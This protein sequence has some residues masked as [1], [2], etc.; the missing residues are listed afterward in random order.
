MPS[1]KSL[2]LG[3]GAAAVFASAA[4]AN[5]VNAT[6]L[7]TGYGKFQPVSYNASTQWDQAGSGPFFSIRAFDHHWQDNDTGGQFIAW[8]IQL[9]QGLTV[10]NVYSFDCVAAENAPTAPPAPGPMGG[11]KA[12][13][14][15]DLFARWADVSTG[16]I[17]PEGTLAATN[18][19]A[20]GFSIVLWEVTHENFTAI[21]EAG[22][23]SQMSLSTGALRANLSADVLAWYNTMQASLGLGGWLFSDLQG[24]TNSTA[25]DQIRLVPSPAALALLG[26]A[27]LVGSRRRRN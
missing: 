4:S 15:R 3:A 22:L 13:V 18:A 27:G 11:I 10:G 14:L 12:N 9:F 23:K 24:L 26:L 16:T 1:L 21:D 5:I 6:Y 2:A 19:K 20:A 8:C 25:Q 17:V 7:G